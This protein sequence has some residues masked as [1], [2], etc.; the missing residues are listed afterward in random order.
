MPKRLVN[1]ITGADRVL[2][3]R[4]A[5]MLVADKSSGWQ[6]PPQKRKTQTKKSDADTGTETGD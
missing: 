6:N 5:R 1:T 4:L 3:T 2:P